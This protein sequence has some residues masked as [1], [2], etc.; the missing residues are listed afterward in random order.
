MPAML[1]RFAELRIAPFHWDETVNVPAASLERD[2]LV[3]LGPVRWR[4]RVSWAEPG[5]YLRARLDY[6]QTLRCDRCLEPITRQSGA[7]VELLLVA[8]PE[9][10]GDEI[11]L[12]EE[13]LG[14]VYVDGEVYDTR[15]LLIEQL[16]L[17]IPMKPVCRPDCRGLCPQCGADLNAG[18]CDCRQEATDPRWAGLTV[19]R[20]RL[21][22][23][24]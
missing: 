11:E 23:G 8:E 18:D 1:I 10:S 14:L 22:G 7:D 15:P 9:P 19:I 24:D 4:G 16:Q 12:G 17:G 6:E 20:D 21:A 3:E 5:Y 2:E 13:D